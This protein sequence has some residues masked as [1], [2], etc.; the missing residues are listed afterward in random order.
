MLLIKLKFKENV[1]SI[2]RV[3]DIKAELLTKHKFRETE[4][5]MNTSN[6]GLSYCF[7]KKISE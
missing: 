7:K 3:E 6:I 5:K 1:Q 4:V 2:W